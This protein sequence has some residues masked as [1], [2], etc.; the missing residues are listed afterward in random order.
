LIRRSST[1][2]SPRTITHR[3]SAQRTSW[4]GDA[5]DHDQL[6]DLTER[7]GVNLFILGHEHAENGYAIVE[8]NAIVLNT[9]HAQG[10]YL[11]IDLEHE[12]TLDQCE[13]QVVR[14]K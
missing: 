8:P 11:P 3:E 4:S 7:W 5:Y 1:A 6:E 9:D 10:V 12:P 2:S 14:I 13:Q